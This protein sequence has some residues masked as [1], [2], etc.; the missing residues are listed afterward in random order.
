MDTHANPT[1]EHHSAA[2]RIARAIGARLRAPIDAEHRDRLA[3]TLAA[4]AVDSGG[5]PMGRAR[6]RAAARWGTPTLRRLTAAAAALVVIGGATGLLLRA[7][8]DL[9]VIVLAGGSLAQAGEGGPMGADQAMGGDALRGMEAA[10][11]MIGLWIP[12]VY[13]FVLADGV[14]IDA[15]RAPAWLLVPPADL[16]A[17][18]ERLTR[19]L[20]VSGL[21]PSEWDPAALNVQLEDGR[22][23]WVSAQGD[24][25]YSGPSSLWPMWDCPEVMPYAGDGDAADGEP[26]EIAPEDYECTPPP[27]SV[28]VPSEAQ[29]RTLASELLARLGHRDVRFENS[30]R[31]E[32]SASV[33]GELLLPDGGGPSGIYVGVG[34]GAN[35]QVTWVNGTLARPERLGDYPLID[36]AAALV[37]LEA[38]LNAWLDGDG[39]MARPMPLPAD[40]TPPGATSPDAPTSDRDAADDGASDDGASEDGPREDDAPVTILPM[41]EPGDVT[42]LPVPEPG[43]DV[44]PVE[45]T[46]T[47]VRVELTSMLVWTADQR[48]VLLPHYRLID[49]DGGWWFVVAVEDRYVA[50]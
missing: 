47:I 38:E 33:S 37:R 44:E 50:R 40:V 13:R 19:E 11:P 16:A 36:A 41:P 27:P 5:E 1:P 35:A 7:S 2:E 32:W 29:A 18:A 43:V 45:R 22:S 34:F 26:R 15:G 21:T 20:G 4:A 6:A 48:V 8:D 10:S 28:G 9:P 25:Y 30:Y 17:A 24:W 14:S 49:A 42:T 12:T 23:L 39:P 31:D 46:V 3:A